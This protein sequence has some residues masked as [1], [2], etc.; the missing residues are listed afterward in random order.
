M[1]SARCWEMRLECECR[2]AATRA[3]N[4]PAYRSNQSCFEYDWLGFYS[5]LPASE[6]EIWSNEFESCLECDVFSLFP[7]EMRTNIVMLKERF[8]HD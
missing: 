7:A 1:A 8:H 4:C 5:K 3:A 2:G 6:Q